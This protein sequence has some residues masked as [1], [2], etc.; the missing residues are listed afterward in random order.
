[1]T[2]QY[3]IVGAGFSGAVVARELA[4]KTDAEILVVDERSHLAGNCHTKRDI[5]T[6]VMIHE[7]GPHIFNTDSLL[8]W[9]Y[10]QRFGRFRSY[11]NR[12]KAFTERGLFSLPVNLMTIN[13]FF[14][15][16]FSPK[17]AKA[18]VLDLGAKF[19]GEPKNLEEQALK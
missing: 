1:M 13:Q 19:V 14:G 9:E 12:V 18:F 4:E 2:S 15:K 3:L 11:T 10:V 5:Q 17:E 8:V 6:G 16:T 7:Y